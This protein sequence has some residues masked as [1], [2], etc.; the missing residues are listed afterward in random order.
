MISGEYLVLSGATALA[1]PV[2]FGQVLRV[3][4][5]GKGDGIR[6][7]WTSRVR[8]REYMNAMFTGREMDV[9]NIEPGSEPE[10]SAGYIR[11]V[12]LAAM[13]LNP[14][15]LSG[16][17]SWIAEADLEFELD[18]GLGSSSSLI[19]NVAYWAGV[20]PYELFFNLSR[21]SGYDIACA[22]SN[23]AVLYKY[24]GPGEQPQ[25]R[26]INFSPP[27]CDRL[28]FVYSGKKQNTDEAIQDFRPGKV[29]TRAINEISAIS[30]KMAETESIDTFMDLVR[31]HEEI[32]AG[33]TG[34]GPVKEREFRNFP[35][36]VKQLGAWGG[37]FL[38]A[39]SNAG[40]DKVMDYFKSTGKETVFSFNEM[41]I[42]KDEQ[43]EHEK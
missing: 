15:F 13:D 21:G 6:L 22:R 25:V 23:N 14:Q 9:S 4:S 29:P 27:F 32:T 10:R 3:E 18:W 33:I 43:K 28:Y 8:G 16:Q 11:R 24:L 7:N 35:G 38:L 41:A 5:S 20:S 1:M 2:R 19:S 39:A 34:V 37:D 40:R 17:L 30:E 31:T 42:R 26:D 12:L 36:E